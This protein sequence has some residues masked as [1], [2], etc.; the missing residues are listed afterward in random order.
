LRSEIA[1]YAGKL[2]TAR[3]D[4]NPLKLKQIVSLHL[5]IGP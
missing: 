4:D 5:I 3:P 2:D 1:S